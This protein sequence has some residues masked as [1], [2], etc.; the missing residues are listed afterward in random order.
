MGVMVINHGHTR[1]VAMV[2]VQSGGRW[3]MAP[4]ARLGGFTCQWHSESR[5]MDGVHLHA[6]KHEHT[7]KGISMMCKMVS[8]RWGLGP[9]VKDSEGMQWREGTFDGKT[10][11]RKGNVK[12]KGRRWLRPGTV[13][14][15]ML[16]QKR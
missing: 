6:G 5:A 3:K 4:V 10:L 13:R 15:P 9:P 2:C 11:S 12:R 14:V 16:G 8:D 7:G 1:E